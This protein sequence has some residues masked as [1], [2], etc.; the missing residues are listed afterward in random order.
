MHKASV[1]GLID[2]SCNWPQSTRKIRG[3]NNFLRKLRAKIKFLRLLF[4]SLRNISPYNPHT[5][6]KM[7]DEVD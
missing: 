5:I 2:A 6:L 7:R 1:K 3:Q 4:L